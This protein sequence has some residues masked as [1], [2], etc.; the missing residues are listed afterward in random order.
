LCGF[1]EPPIGCA[2][3]TFA[4]GIATTWRK[5]DDGIVTNVASAIPSYSFGFAHP[6][7]P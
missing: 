7:P 1:V 4:Q 6:L 3:F 5:S 2:R